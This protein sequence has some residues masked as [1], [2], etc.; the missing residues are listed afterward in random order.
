[1][2]KVSII[3][4]G[5]GNLFSIQNA[6]SYVGINSIITNDEKII[7][8]SDAIIL[9]GVGSFEHAMSSLDK[10]KL[11]D[12]IISFA[13]SGR[14]LI[15][16]CLGMQLLFEKSYE[17]GVHHGLGLISG[18]VI[19]LDVDYPYTVPQV[20]W[21][22]LNFNNEKKHLIFNGINERQYFYFVHS[23]IC[24]PTNNIQIA[25]TTNYDSIDF[26]SSVINKNIYGFQFHPERSAEAGLIIYKNLKKII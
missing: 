25:T 20:Q 24:K 14:P 19:K 10:L 9:P 26:C 2:K 13:N 1:M 12:T 18:E 4:Y 7:N 11:I 15:G 23:F 17:F 6:C 8:K 5:L 16:V 22:R 3:N 21:N